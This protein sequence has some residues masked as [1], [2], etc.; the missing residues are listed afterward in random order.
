MVSIL[1][2][3]LL[4]VSCAPAQSGKAAEAE[5]E[6]LSD[7]ELEQAIAEG[8]AAESAAVAG[9]AGGPEARVSASKLGAAYKVAYKRLSSKPLVAQLVP[10]CPSTY[11]CGE[12][13]IPEKV[14]TIVTPE[15]R[16][17]CGSCP[18]SPQEICGEDHKCIGIY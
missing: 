13:V 15:Q 12:Y 6:Q 4:V 17:N 10:S 18:T 3:S 11:E 9:Q 16:L 2:F 14:E 5:L 1:A 8:E 7:A